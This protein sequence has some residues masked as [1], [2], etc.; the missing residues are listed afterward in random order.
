MVASR[1]AFHPP[2]RGGFTLLEVL[3]VL[4]LIT[5]L[6]GLALAAMKG[7]REQARSTR[8]LAHLRQWPALLAAYAAEHDGETP[9]RGQGVRPLSTI[10]RAEDWFN[11]LPRYAGLPAYVDRVRHGARHFF[12]HLADHPHF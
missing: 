2:R 1:P 8:C 5:V 10:N 9:R 3:V 6:T 7:A 12:F 11:A 4:A